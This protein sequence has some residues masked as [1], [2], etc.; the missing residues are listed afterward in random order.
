VLIYER[1]CPKDW[2]FLSV[3]YVKILR[4]YELHPAYLGK[5]PLKRSKSCSPFL[6]GDTAQPRGILTPFSYGDFPLK[7][8]NKWSTATLTRN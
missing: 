6:K 2:K 3:Q 7:G 4:I 5:P 8:E 1:G